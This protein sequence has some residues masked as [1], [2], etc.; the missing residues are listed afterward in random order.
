MPAICLPT[1]APHTLVNKAKNIDVSGD[2][3]DPSFLP[4]TL[5]LCWTLPFWRK[6]TTH[7]QYL[8]SAVTLTH[9]LKTWT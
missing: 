4:P 3:T 8:S 1:S 9:N 5:I 7:V 2:L 6:Q